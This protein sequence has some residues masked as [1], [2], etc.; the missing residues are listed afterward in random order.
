MIESSAQCLPDP[1]VEQQRLH[2]IFFEPAR[3]AY[4]I[5]NGF[6][7]TKLF[8][9]VLETIDQIGEENWQ[10]HK[11]G[12]YEGVDIPF[13]SVSV[14]EVAARILEKRGRSFT[15]KTN[16]PDEPKH[17]EIV[18]LGW[19]F[20][21]NGHPFSMWCEAYDRIIKALPKYI[22]ELQNYKNPKDKP[23]RDTQVITLGQPHGLSGTVTKEWIA[24][25]RS[26]GFPVYGQEYAQLLRERAFISLHPESTFTFMGISMGATLADQTARALT[27]LNSY[28]QQEINKK[29]NPGRSKCK[30]LLYLPAGIDPHSTMRR[31][32]QFPIGFG[33]EGIRFTL[34]KFFGLEQSHLP[35]FS[36]YIKNVL[37]HKG[38]NTT[39]GTVPFS[40]I[41]QL[42]R[43]LLGDHETPFPDSF[44]QQDLKKM[45]AYADFLNIID[46]AD[47][48]PNIN[49]NIL[50]GRFDPVN[51]TLH[52]IMHHKRGEFFDVDKLGRD[53]LDKDKLDKDKL[54]KAKSDGDKPDGDKRK[55]RHRRFTVDTTHYI[56]YSKKR[57]KRWGSKMEQLA[58]RLDPSQTSK[59][60]R[61]V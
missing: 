27:E 30:L 48:D 1:S 57:A 25:V 28:K 10:I 61:I 34:D 3:R 29:G 56:S 14:S 7:N 50:A 42:F 45:V 51:T 47:L 44:S 38:I 49:A 33:L 11:S 15:I 13:S 46:G 19:S 6:E 58:V 17:T 43:T 55:S 16:T 53:K 59:K 60:I 39:D 8:C 9:E 31:V 12:Q 21:P 4:Y 37:E 20:P 35:A 23:P 41:Q 24:A 26:Q 5:E 18:F 40:S 52:N 36:A 54:E 32:V 2:S 22:E